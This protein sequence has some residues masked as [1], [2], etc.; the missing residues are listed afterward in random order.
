MRPMACRVVSTALA[1]CFCTA[2]AK[3][4]ANGGYKIHG[5][6]YQCG[7]YE[8]VDAEFSKDD[9]IKYGELSA[10]AYQDGKSSYGSVEG[11]T[12]LTQEET[13][14]LLGE[15]SALRVSLDGNVTISG[16]N[17]TRLNAIIYKKCNAAGV[18][19]EY[20]ISYRGSHEL[21]DWVD[22]A[23]QAADKLGVLPQQYKDA[24]SLLSSVLSNT[25][26]TKEK[27]TCTGHS[28]G[29][30]LV[31]YSMASV[32]YG[33]R[34]V[35]GYTYNAA[36][37]SEKTMN[38]LDSANVSNAADDI[39]NIRNQL[40]PVSYVAYHIGETYEVVTSSQGT[41][42]TIRGDHSLD[43]L[44]DNMYAEK[45]ISLDSSGALALSQTGLQLSAT[46]LVSQRQQLELDALN[47]ELVMGDPSTSDLRSLVES[48]MQSEL[49]AEIER[50][51]SDGSYSTGFPGMEDIRIGSDLERKSSTDAVLDKW[52]SQAD[53]LKEV[54][55]TDED[56]SLFQQAVDFVKEKIS[57]AK[58][59]GSAWVENGGIRQLIQ[60]KLSDALDGKV[61]DADKSRVLNLADKLCNIGSDGG[62]SFA[63]ALGSDGIDLVKSLAV[64]EIRKQ[65]ESA[66]PKDSADN[67]CKYLEM[68]LVDGVDM[69]DATARQQLL[70]T[71]KAGI[72]DALPYGNAADIVNGL[73]QDIFDGKAVNVIESAQMLG[74]SVGIDVLKSTITDTIGGEAAE[75]INSILDGYAKDGLNGLTAAA[76]QEINALIDQYAP[77][78]ASAEKLKNTVDGVLK[79]TVVSEDIKDAA[80]ELA[81]DYLNKMIDASGLDAAAKDAAKKAV[82]ELKQNGIVKI[83]ETVSHFIEDYVADKLGSEEAG[84]A[85]ADVFKNI[86][87][88][89]EDVWDALAKD[90][91][92]IGK[93]IGAKILS[94]VESWAAKQIDKFVNSH[95]VLK[96]VFGALGLSG[97]NIVA[98]IKNIWGIFA[99]AGS[100]VDA[101][102]ELGARLVADLKQIAINLLKWGL[103]KFTAWVNNLVNKVIDKIVKLIEK[104]IAS[105]NNSILKA[106]LGWI[107]SQLAAVK[108]KGAIITMMNSMN[109]KAVEWVKGKLNKPSSD[110]NAPVYEGVFTRSS[111][112]NKNNSKESAKGGR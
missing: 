37:L 43:G 63:E 56:K 93:A 21:G 87:H 34:D 84:K 85:A 67:I 8:S 5:N 71:I 88:P 77:G 66:L 38:S 17:N 39:L 23:K 86:I 35:K 110:P 4:E 96:E 12:Q 29:G 9:A 41:K 73:I 52:Q 46:E 20:V 45:A 106:G 101:F 24:A 109:A 61:S 99:K 102:K 28:L 51:V 112:K 76:Q 62:K 11:Y 104:L 83:D 53:A 40:D 94:K 108:K 32:N 3:T 64:A 57:E 80:T 95:P 91:Q 68:V 60:E 26:E 98:G 31:A 16:D 111:G 44:L 92:V 36:G 70:N 90:A 74:L 48:G 65:L 33:E 13:L 81:S 82:E 78:T 107:K 58:E 19:E 72:K 30:G 69:M 47:V 14:K 105:S 59:K 50:I 55:T 27:I 15:G 6:G 103:Q 100:I 1:M 49:L 7:L 54:L 2:W 42:H 97:S 22:D 18:P 75:K 25:S 79:G 89:S 10:A